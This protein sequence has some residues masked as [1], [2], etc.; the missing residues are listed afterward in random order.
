MLRLC[1]EAQVVLEG[2]RQV[3]Q[4]GLRL[5]AQEDLRLVAYPQ[6]GSR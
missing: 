1:Q 2:L 3:A 5:V 6:A 4:V